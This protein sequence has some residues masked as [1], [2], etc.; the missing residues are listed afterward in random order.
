MAQRISKLVHDGLIEIDLTLSWFTRRIR[1][2]WYNKRLI[3]AYTGV[4][5]PLRVTK[6]NLPVD[7]LNWRIRTMV[8]VTRGQVV[9]EI[10]KDIYVNRNYPP[11]SCT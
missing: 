6:D 8:K 9:P 5:D 3:C 7:S 4:D 10:S 2:L 1:P 11:V